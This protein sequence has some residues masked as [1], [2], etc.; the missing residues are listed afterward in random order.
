MS[1]VWQS[2]VLLTQVTDILGDKAR[3][4]QAT[5]LASPCQAHLLGMLCCR[6]IC[7]RDTHQLRLE[8]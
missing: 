7:S 2:F 6:G 8:A 5:A 1:R 3:R 4:S